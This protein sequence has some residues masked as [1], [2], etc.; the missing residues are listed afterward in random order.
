[1]ISDSAQKIISN[2]PW[3]ARYPFW[4]T[5]EMIRRLRDGAG[6]SHV[7]FIVANHF[8]PGYNEYPNEE[9]GLGVVLDWDTQMRRLDDW[10]E[11]ARRI[12]EAVRDHDGTKFRHTNFYPIEQYNS[13]LLERMAEMQAAGLGEVEIHLHHGVKAP[14]TAENLRNI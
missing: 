11:Q 8:E 1:M 12:G 13:R 14:D 4:R 2:L 3:L 9:G 5:N 7:I 6:E 10:C